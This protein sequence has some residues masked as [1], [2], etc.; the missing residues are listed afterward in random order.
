MLKKHFVLSGDY[1]VNNYGE[2]EPASYTDLSKNRRVEI[3]LL[4]LKINTL[5]PDTGKLKVIRSLELEHLYF[6][7]DEPIL[8]PSSMPYLDYVASILKKDNKDIFEIKGHVNWSPSSNSSPDLGYKKKMDQL[9]A[10]RARMIYDI[11]VDKGIP[12]GRMFWKGMGN[13]EMIYPNASSD[14]E[15]RKNMRVEILVL[16]RTDE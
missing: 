12:P 10:D 7:P 13:T 6:R 5:I 9:S 2:R 11:L 1:D 8:E 15:K 14:E 16:K 4:P 3:S